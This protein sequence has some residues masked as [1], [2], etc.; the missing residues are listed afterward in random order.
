MQRQ[1]NVRQYG[2]NG[3]GGT[4]RIAQ[5]AQRAK[6]GGLTN[7]QLASQDYKDTRA[8]RAV[9]RN[10]SLKNR[11]AVADALVRRA[12][13][14]QGKATSMENARVSEARDRAFK[15]E[16]FA[17]EQ[18]SIENRY[19]KQRVQWMA[20]GMTD[21]ELD[22]AEQAERQGSYDR[23]Y[24]PK[25]NGRSG[26]TASGGIDPSSPSRQFDSAILPDG[27]GVAKPVSRQ[28]EIPGGP[29]GGVPSDYSD[30]ISP[31]RQRVLD[32]WNSYQESTGV[33][34]SRDD[35]FRARNPNPSFTMPGRVN[36]LPSGQGVLAPSQQQQPMAKPISMPLQ[37]SMYD[38]MEPAFGFG[39]DPSRVMNQVPYAENSVHG[40]PW[41]GSVPQPQFNPSVRR[42]GLPPI[43]IGQGQKFFRPQQPSRSLQY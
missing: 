4:N 35:A 12:E 24:R 10:P 39:N 42:P 6:N 17:R 20:D 5:D 11:P 18:K 15:D 28:L 23:H 2:E 3:L 14:V 37:S 32:D 33:K 1:A 21:Q 34:Q 38:Q 40:I 30:E 43:P 31:R 27:A 22:Q 36:M 26:M 41:P 13:S 19:A 7:S 9:G 29:P 25:A 16:S 8:L